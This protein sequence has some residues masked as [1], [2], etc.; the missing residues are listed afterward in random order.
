MR[1]R[2]LHLVDDGLAAALAREIILYMAYHTVCYTENEK[3]LSFLT[4]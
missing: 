4:G 1:A 2:A 3:E